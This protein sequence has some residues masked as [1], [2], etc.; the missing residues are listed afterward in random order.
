M[1]EEGVLMTGGEEE[2]VGRAGG[3][4]DF[5]PYNTLNFTVLVNL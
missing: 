4:G 2:G 1:E 3:E 5:S